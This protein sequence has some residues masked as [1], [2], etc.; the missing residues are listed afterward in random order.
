MDVINKKK[1]EFYTPPMMGHAYP[2]AKV[3]E[4]VQANFPEY[5][6]T[7]ITL[8]NAKQRL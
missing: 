3:A 5:E 2:L 7:F 8:H 1:I 4:L 6:V